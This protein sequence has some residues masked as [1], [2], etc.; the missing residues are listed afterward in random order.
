MRLTG[1]VSVGLWRG[2]VDYRH[3]TSEYLFWWESAVDQPKHKQVIIYWTV[4][5]YK[6]HILRNLCNTAVICKR[7]FVWAVAVRATS[8][9]FDGSIMSFLTLF[10]DYE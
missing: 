4:V 7:L 2:V 6:A 9:K 5:M 10:C 1:G 8:K 3:G